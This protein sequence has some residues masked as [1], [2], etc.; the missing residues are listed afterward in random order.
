MTQPAHVSFVIPVLN[1]ERDIGRC[2]DAID[3]L[4]TGTPAEVIVL[5]NGS[6]DR[7]LEVVE[8]R[9]RTCV[10]MPGVHVAA[11][12]NRG[13]ALATGSIMAFVDADVEVGRE[14]L[15]AMLAAFDEPGVVAAGCFPEIPAPSTWVQRAWDAHQRRPGDARRRVAWLPSM[16]LAVRRADFLAVGGFD[17]RLET[18]ED[19]DLCYR[20]GA[21]GPIVLEPGMRAVHWGEAP[22]V[23]TFWRKERWRGVG[24]L[25][26]VL[27]HGFRWDELPSVAYP[28]Y[29]L[30]TICLVVV[31]GAVD[32]WRQQWGLF[33]IAV[34]ASTLPALALS[35]TAAVRAGRP[36]IGPALCLLYFLYGAA[37]ACSIVR[38]PRKK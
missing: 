17:E 22:D 9:G 11:L 37:R 33:P 34:I 30:L 1:G 5:D 28:L 6:T 12:R 32:L 27:A 7:T 3:R 14:W 25:H 35:A 23:R 8:A 19:V 31:G 15:A 24:N 38:P 21:R 4:P 13:V 2:L 29:M 20:L 16:N 26:G 10:A 18:A 36:Q